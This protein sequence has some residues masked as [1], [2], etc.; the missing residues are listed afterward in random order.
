MSRYGHIA[1]FVVKRLLVGVVVIWAVV[2]FTFALMHSPGAPDPIREILGSHYTAANYAQLKHEYGVDISTWDQYLQYIGLAPFLSTVGIHIGHGA[3]V[4]GLIQGNFGYSFSSVGVPVW[5]ILSPG[6]PVTLKLGLYALLVSLTFG[7]P[8]GLI[9]ALKQNTWVDHLGQGSMMVIYALPTFVLAPILQVVVALQWGLLPVSGWGDNWQE[10]VLPIA[11]YSAGLAGFFAKSFRSFMLE[12]L[13]QDYIRTARAK[14]LSQ[15]IIVFRHAVKNS[16]I[17]L[18]SV[19]GPVVGYL[20]IGSFIIELFF[21]VPG[22][23]FVTVQASQSNDY[24]I[25]EATT[26]LLAGF[27]VVVNMLSD[28]AYTFIDP[29]VKL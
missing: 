21:R 14:G 24:A 9:S 2:T 26:I 15:R 19:V 7:I 12:V 28:I 27:V 13:Q 18:V 6:A 17:P 10:M 22:I 20:I 1:F 29:R 4:T 8:I 23:A 3:V 16:L 11:V 5:D 25:V